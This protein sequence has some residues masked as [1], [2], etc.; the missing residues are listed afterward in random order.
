MYDYDPKEKERYLKKRELYDYYGIPYLVF[1]ESSEE[2]S[3]QIKIDRF[4]GMALLAQGK[5]I[6]EDLAKRLLKYKKADEERE[7]RQVKNDKVKGVY[8]RRKKEEC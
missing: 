2:V 6:P 3:K 4:N 7:R 8:N 1:D 5:P